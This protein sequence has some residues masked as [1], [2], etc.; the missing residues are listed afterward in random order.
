MK[1]TRKITEAPPSLRWHWAAIKTRILYR[2]AFGLIG[3]G[4][5][6]VDPKILRGVENIFIGDRCSIYGGVW[7]QCEPECGPI[8]VGEGTYLG[9]DV[10]IHAIDPITVGA[11]CV[12][13][14][15]VFVGSSDHG[16]NNRAEVVPSGPIV[17]GDNV[18]VGQRAIILGGVTIGDGA[19]IGAGS[20]VTKDVAPGA[21]V[22]G[23][24]ARVIGGRGTT[25]GD[26]PAV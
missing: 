22:A 13:A 26:R 2:K 23:V 10:H 25:A 6:I 11:H 21:V 1:I 19:T 7:L 15:G 8:R 20:V 24:P 14:D 9:H 17:I 4:T 12:F 3:R 16:R 5:V 18:F